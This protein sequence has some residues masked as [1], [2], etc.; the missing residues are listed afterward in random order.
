MSNEKTLWIG[1]AE[2]PRFSS[3]KWVTQRETEPKENAKV[4]FDG[5]WR[6]VLPN[7]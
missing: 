4:L 2:N 6:I 3:L 5:N 7:Q 1:V